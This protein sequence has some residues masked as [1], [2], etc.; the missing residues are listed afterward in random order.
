M[1][2]RESG[3][4]EEALWATFFNAETAL[5]RL[6]PNP[7]GD[8]VELGCGF[9][10]FTLVAARHTKGTIT[11]LDID[12]EMIATVNAKAE[13]LG[14]TNIQALE[15]DFVAGDLGVAPGSQAHVMI[16]NLLHMEQ[17][18]SLLR[19][20][21]EALETDGT[22]SVMHWRSDVP[23]PRGPPM[24]IRPT[25]EDCAAWLAEAGFTQ[26]EHVDL[27]GSCPFH[28]GLIAWR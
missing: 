4:P 8:A 20:A 7:Y 9:G 14:L 6:W 5:A 21:Y 12:P 24:E 2:C 23:T 13:T 19:K 10:T 15:H 18:V 3:M 1:K 22:V 17:P 28:Y 25:A 27:S 11:A 16:Y 26:I